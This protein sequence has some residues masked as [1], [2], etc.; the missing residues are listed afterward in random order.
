MESSSLAHGGCEE[1][2]TEFISTRGIRGVCLLAPYR[3]VWGAVTAAPTFMLCDK[4]PHFPKFNN[5][6]ICT[7]CATKRVIVL[8]SYEST[9]YSGRYVSRDKIFRIGTVLPWLK[10][11]V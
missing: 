9:L 4:R 8:R 1:A 2:N 5:E 7:W 6:I 10:L 11:S 3:K